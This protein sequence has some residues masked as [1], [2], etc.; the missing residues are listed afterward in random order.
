MNVT[1][2][3]CVLDSVNGVAVGYC[4]FRKCNEAEEK[5]T[6]ALRYVLLIVGRLNINYICS[7]LNAVTVRCNV[8]G[9]H[10]STVTATQTAVYCRL[11][12]KLTHK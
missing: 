1:T 9:N 12:N 5:I 8:K 11:T 4:D 2:F 6:V 10:T 7:V 3:D